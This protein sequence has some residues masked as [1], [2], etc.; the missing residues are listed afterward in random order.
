MI[1][2]KLSGL[3]AGFAFLLSL[4]IGLLS[5]SSVPS[6]FIRALIFAVFFF[7]LS[8]LITMLVSRYLPEL[9][10][11]QE[12]PVPDLA[13]PGSRIN[14]REELPTVN[15]NVLYARPDET[16]EGLGNISDAL[17]T[18]FA[19]AG[20]PGA[21]L[22]GANSSYER[23]NPA[24]MPNIPGMDQNEQNDYN[25]V[26]IS[27]PDTRGGYD[28]LPDLESLAGAFLPSAGD[29]ESDNQEYPGS[30]GPNRPLTGNKPQKMD[31]DFHPKELAAGIRTVLK[32]QEG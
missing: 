21:G 24:E 16:D 5:G 2:F 13:I 23:Q 9:L 7:A 1:N 14:I 11:E 31:A 30:N 29:K 27:V 3:I 10:E 22:S 4:L 25:G 20:A 6:L 8:I 19:V 12:Q 26:R 15:P 32:K 17:Q 18:G 28:V